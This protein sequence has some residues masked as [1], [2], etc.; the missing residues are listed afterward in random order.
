MVSQIAAGYGDIGEGCGRQPGVSG[1]LKG[2]MTVELD[3]AN[4]G[5]GRYVLEVKN[6]RSSLRAALAETAKAM[7]NRDVAASVLVFARDD[8]NPCR[9]PLQTFAQVIVV[10]VDK[11]DPEPAALRLAC[12]WARLAAP[13]GTQ[14]YLGGPRRG[15]DAGAHCQAPTVPDPGEHHTAATIRSAPKKLPRRRR[16]CRICWPG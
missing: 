10:T 1:T 15:P 9:V 14:R 11:D 8:Q 16:A 3:P 13:R 2:D 5:P 4:A 7:A 12:A 6:T